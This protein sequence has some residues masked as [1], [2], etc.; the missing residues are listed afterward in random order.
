MKLNSTRNAI[1]KNLWLTAITIVLFGV[2]T[3]LFYS[4][5]ISQT[6]VYP[7]DIQQHM[8]F[9][10]NGRGYSLLYRVMEL[11]YNLTG[12]SFSIAIL[13]SLLT[14]GTWLGAA[15]LI[16][17]LYERKD[18]FSSAIIALP[19]MFV[20]GIYIPVIYEYFYKQQIVTQPHHNITYTGMRFFAVFAMIAFCKIFES[21]LKKNKWYHWVMLAVML[22]LATSIKPSFLYG[23]VFT[24]LIFLILDFTKTK[25]NTK[26]LLK[27]VISVGIMIPLLFIMLMQAKI[28]YARPAEAGGSG[29]AIVWG[30]NFVS[31]GVWLTL[32]KILCGL[33]FPVLVGLVN[34]K[35]LKRTEKFTYVM[36]AVQLAIV[37]LFVETGPRAKHGNFYWGLYG[38]AFF[39]FII[40][41]AR[42]ADNLKHYKEHN[43]I[44][45]GAGSLLM[46]AHIIS[47]VG[48][49]VI[50]LLGNKPWTI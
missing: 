13:E 37:M 38:A 50:V 3:F 8:D 26:P 29:I 42:F 19:S 6:E 2:F 7:S 43:K 48:Y 35:Q 24:L 12:S 47:G 32:L 31:T 14:V 23:F 36:Y 27:I 22:A 46:L 10:I 44:Y 49:F 17:F 30:K 15:K 11:L 18:Y 28:L 45:I 1:M 34:H 33:S 4:Q 25:S 5:L 20:T 39:L 9:A 16:D 40:T 21:Y 41:F